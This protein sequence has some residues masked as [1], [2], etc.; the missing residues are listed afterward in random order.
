MLAYYWDRLL[1]Q[2][3]T[4][5]RYHQSTFWRSRLVTTLSVPTLSLLAWDLDLGFRK[6]EFMRSHVRRSAFTVQELVV[7]ESMMSLTRMLLI[8]K[9]A[10]NRPGYKDPV[11]WDSMI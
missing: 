1:P 9:L 2:D 7:V 4:L 11:T 3:W 8:S 5:V 10:K 6:V